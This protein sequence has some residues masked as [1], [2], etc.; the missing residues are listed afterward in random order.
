VLDAA[1]RRQHRFHDV[2]N[3]GAGVT[4]VGKA[5]GI[6]DAFEAEAARL[7]LSDLAA[8]CRLPV[9]TTHRLVTELVSWGA[10]ERGSDGRYTLGLRLWELGALAPRALG[11]RQ[12]AMPVLE[13]LYEATH[14]NVQLC[15]REGQ[16]VVFI[17]RISGRQAVG[18]VS[19]VGGRLPAHATSGGQVMLAYAPPATRRQAL[20]GPLPA[21]TPKTITDPD[22]LRSVLAEIRRSGFVVCDGHVTLDALAV[23]APIRGVGDVVVAA[24]SVVVPSVPGAEVPLV[25]AVVAAARG[26]SR[27]LGA[28][29][30]SSLST[31]WKEP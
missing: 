26:I 31:S 15:V 2:E 10:L 23:A 14:E 1:A 27:S 4:A 5:L 28:P 12:C 17:E 3:G 9:S 16:E 7:T 13:D 24:V 25:P 6:L 11:L 22:R 29:S 30:A 19:R 21:Y 20:A 18:V 8:R